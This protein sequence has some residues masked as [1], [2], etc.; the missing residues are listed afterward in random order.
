MKQLKSFTALEQSVCKCLKFECSVSRQLS[1]NLTQSQPQSKLHTTTM[2]TLRRA[3]ASTLRARIG[4]RVLPIQELN[5]TWAYGPRTDISSVQRACFNNPIYIS[6]Y[7]KSSLPLNRLT[8]CVF[9]A[10]TALRRYTTPS[11]RISWISC[12]H[13]Q[14]DDRSRS[15]NHPKIYKR[16]KQMVFEADTA[17]EQILWINARTRK[18]GFESFIS[19]ARQTPLWK[20][21]FAK[22]VLS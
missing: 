20:N 22:V 13:E 16:A 19:T 3:T 8:P 14:H 4:T 6:N 9:E 18:L 21:C 17:L 10:S 15:H 1:H 2:E 11:S 7:T 5:K 12:V